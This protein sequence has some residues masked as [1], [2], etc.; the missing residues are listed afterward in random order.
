M[1]IKSYFCF[2]LFDSLNYSLSKCKW[3]ICYGSGT[4][5]IMMSKQTEAFLSWED[6]LIR[7]GAI[8]ITRNGQNYCT[9]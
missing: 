3:R 1:K 8:F 9:L 5:D 2:L 6:I 4:G 7:I